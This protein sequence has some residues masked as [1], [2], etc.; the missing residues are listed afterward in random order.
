MSEHYTGTSVW[1]S[2]GAIVDLARPEAGPYLIEDIA[3]RLSV[4]Y[5]YGGATKFTYSV[6]QHSILMSEWLGELKP[7]EPELWQAAMLHDAAEAYV[8]DMHRGVKNLLK[9]I[10]MR[11][12]NLPFN[13][14]QDD[15][16]TGEYV[17]GNVAD[18]IQ[19]IEATITRYIFVRFGLDP[20]LANHELVHEA[21]QRICLDEM[22]TL[23]DAGYPESEK[24]GREPLKVAVSDLEDSHVEESFLA[25]FERLSDLIQARFRP[26]PDASH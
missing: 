19:D 4:T 20:E 5:R 16:L 10:P 23:Y 18:A 24:H 7:S 6:A 21:D 26:T 3:Q 25:R 15:A 1:M 8:G 13:P 17:V 9:T 22:D 11:G 14:V 12:E 2:S